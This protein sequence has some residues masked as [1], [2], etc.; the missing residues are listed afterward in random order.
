MENTDKA[1][2]FIDALRK[3]SDPMMHVAAMMIELQAAILD[4]LRKNA[5]NRK[6]A[7]ANWNATAGNPAY[8]L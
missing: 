3:N 2:V 1:R 4:E 5:D 6:A 8:R 7:L